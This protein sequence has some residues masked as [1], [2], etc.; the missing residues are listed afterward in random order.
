M[1]LGRLPEIKEKARA[2]V[3]DKMPDGA[4]T[5][6]RAREL[7]YLERLTKEVRRARTV[8]PV[9]FFARAKADCAFEGVAVPRGMKA[10]GAIGATLHDGSIFPEPDAFD[11][12]RWLP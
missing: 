5:Y 4:V 12:D 6:A 2:E 10:I 11:P 3:R 9:T 8:V 7:P 1:F